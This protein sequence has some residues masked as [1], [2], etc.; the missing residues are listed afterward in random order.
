MAV[1]FLLSPI[2]VGGLGLGIW[3]AFP[4][5]R[6]I[7]YLS[8]I[9]WIAPLLSIA[10]YGGGFIFSMA[11]DALYYGSGEPFDWGLHY[12][13]TTPMMIAGLLLAPLSVIFNLIAGIIDLK[14]D[15]SEPDDTD[16]P[17]NAPENPRNQLDV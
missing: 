9:G 6:W 16:N 4:H 1:L 2:L 12:D 15:K 5:S 14:K 13:L 8:R 10:L 7:S 11:G 3:S 17:V